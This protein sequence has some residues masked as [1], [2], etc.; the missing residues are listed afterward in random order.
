MRLGIRTFALSPTQNELEAR[1]IP[2]ARGVGLCAVASVLNHSCEP[3]V[4][5]VF[6]EGEPTVG[7]AA[8]S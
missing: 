5:V 8:T 3:N 4:E 1:Q 2:P 6:D 7:G